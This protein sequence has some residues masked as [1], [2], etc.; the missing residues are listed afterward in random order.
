MEDDG[1]DEV[2]NRSPLRSSSAALTEA[3]STSA[4]MEDEG[5]EDDEGEEEAKAVDDGERSD[6][7]DWEEQAEGGPED[8]DDGDDDDG[9]NEEE[10]AEEGAAAAVRAAKVATPTRR[11]QRWRRR[12]VK[13]EEE[14]S[15]SEED[16]EGGEVEGDG[17][18]EAVA[19]QEEEGEGEEEERPPIT[20]G[21]EVVVTLRSLNSHLACSLCKG[22]YREATAIIECAHTCQRSLHTPHTCALCISASAQGACAV[23]V[24]KV[25]LSNYID[26]VNEHDEP[27]CPKR[28]CT[29]KLRSAD[30][31]RNETKSDTADALAGIHRSAAATHVQFSSS[32][33]N[34]SPSLRW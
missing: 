27:E 16:G 9:A 13:M 22:Y 26:Q 18:E 33:A 11:P 2:K 29:V 10:E 17:G 6:D 31:L 1:E 14:K 25:C 15:K 8:E 32:L 30:P 7:E 3:P 19:A 21:R 23:T 12:K 4:R 24:C 28:G 5:E 20:D 34:H